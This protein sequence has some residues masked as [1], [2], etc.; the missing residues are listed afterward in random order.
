MTHGLETSADHAATV[1]S[2]LLRIVGERGL[3]VDDDIRLRSADPARDVPVQGIA[4]V[5]PGTVEE[6]AAVVG[7]CSELR[8]TMVVHG[9]RTGVSG[10]A[11]T[12][13]CDVVLSL[14][15]L[16]RIE[17]ISEDA[18]IAVVEAGVTIE[19]LHQAAAR[20]GL[21][22]PVDMGSKG[23]ATIGGSIATNAGGNHVI[24]WGMTRQNVRGLEVVLPDGTV[25]SS[26]NR[27]L[28]NNTGYDLKQLFIG[29]EGTL[30]V[31]T[32][33]VVQLVPQPVTQDVAFLALRNFGDVV[34]LMNR[35]RRMTILSAFEVMWSDYYTLMAES[36]TGRAPLPPD[37]PFYVLIETLGQDREADSARFEAF[38]TLALEDGLVADAVVAS[39]LGQAGKL[40]KV[41]EGG[42]VMKDKMGPYVPFD[43]SLDLSAMATFVEQVH[44][45]I[46]R[47]IPDAV[48][49]T[50]GHLGDNNIH[51]GIHAGTRTASLEDEIEAIVYRRV[52][53]HGGS[54]SAE[55][56]IGQRKKS[57]FHEYGS[58]V[59]LQL[60]RRVK[61]MFDPHNLMNP[62]VLF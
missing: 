22:Y 58:S 18:Q 57:F 35:A 19:A 15:R 60:M 46:R 42:E 49:V 4:I 24:R 51:F 34:A 38:V 6:V 40:W 13:S 55:H 25:L 12:S 8:Q 2:A 43:V 53:E 21:S 31:V 37:F 26:M 32:R 5:R 3:L 36:E 59:E 44:D 10:G 30:G 52:S 50:F 11:Y 39:S 28:K 7:C 45:D 27:L 48:G 29:S 54:I 61:S 47:N 41:R 23:S 16:N 62:K 17:E 1:R 56:G 14:E 9:G 33:A 20:H